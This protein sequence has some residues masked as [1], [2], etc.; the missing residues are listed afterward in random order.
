MKV[1]NRFFEEDK[2]GSYLGFS[3][4]GNRLNYVNMNAVHHRLC[5]PARV[6]NNDPSESQRLFFNLWITNKGRDAVNMSS[7]FRHRKVSLVFHHTSSLSLQPVFPYTSTKVS[8]LFNHKQIAVSLDDI[9]TYL[10]I[11]V[12][13]STIVLLN[14]PLVVMSV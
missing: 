1:L 11:F 3:T 8:K 4:P 9:Q 7:I 14:M 13:L 12:P 2:D 6:S 5:K 10:H